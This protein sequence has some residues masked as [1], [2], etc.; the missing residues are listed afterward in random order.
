M[1]NDYDS[2]VLIIITNTFVNYNLPYMYIVTNNYY[3]HVVSFICSLKAYFVCRCKPKTFAISIALIS[4]S[5][6]IYFVVRVI[7]SAFAL[8]LTH[9]LSPL[10]LSHVRIIY[11]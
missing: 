2:Y 3:I 6:R 11:A 9:S 5:V 1:F 10:P 8:A 4:L 7:F